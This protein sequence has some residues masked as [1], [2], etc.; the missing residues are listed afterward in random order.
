M[1]HLSN[2]GSF[3]GSMI[4]DCNISADEGLIIRNYTVL[5]DKQYL[6]STS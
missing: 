2:V 1:C 3:Y 5:A 4:D 6:S